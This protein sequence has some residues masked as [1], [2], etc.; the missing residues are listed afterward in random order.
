MFG[1]LF[2]SLDDTEPLQNMLIL[3]PLFTG[4]IFH[5]YS[6]EKSICILGESGL[7]CPIYSIFIKMPIANNE[8][9]YQIPHCVVSDLGLHCLSMTLLRVSR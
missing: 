3:Y 9:P 7:F 8:G 1:I 4:G 6:L 2:A 5:C